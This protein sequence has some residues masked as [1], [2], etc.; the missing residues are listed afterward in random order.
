MDVLFPFGAVKPGSRIVLYGAGGLGYKLYRQIVTSGYCQLVSWVDKQYE[1][2]HTL[3][4]PV[5][6]PNPSLAGQTDMF[7][8]AAEKELSYKSIYRVLSSWGVPSEKIY[9][10]DDYGLK[11]DI[12]AKY[13]EQRMRK[14]AETAE[15]IEPLQLV[16]DSRMDIVVRVMYAREFLQ[17][18]KDGD[19]YLLYLKLM[20]QVNGFCEDLDNFFLAYFSDYVA[21]RGRMEFLEAF[22]R[23]LQSMREE[24]F[25]K[26]SFIPLN[27]QGQLINGAHRCAA[28]I[29]LGIKVFARRYPCDG[30]TFDYSAR[31]LR[32]RGFSEQE[33]GKIE[34]EYKMLLS[35]NAKSY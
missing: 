3:N 26:K 22:Q 8:I 16:T 12:V 6:P 32:E 33:V 28:A 15:A 27:R 19:G 34:H 17:N 24:G 14:E 9:W 18:I 21:K 13:D 10:Q 35:G 2:Y 5:D 4:L 1:W 30:M 23:I 31:W 20:E 7:I 29:A 25:R 11:A